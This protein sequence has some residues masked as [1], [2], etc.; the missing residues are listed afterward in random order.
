MFIDIQKNSF[1]S[2][3]ALSPYTFY[4]GTLSYFY[5]RTIKEIFLKY[6]Q[7]EVGLSQPYDTEQNYSNG[8]FLGYR[9]IISK[10]LSAGIRL[11]YIQLKSLKTDLFMIVFYIAVG[12]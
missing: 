12:F 1:S 9:N 6:S 5:Y 7:L 11:N 8:Y 2:K 10:E 3:I 4:V